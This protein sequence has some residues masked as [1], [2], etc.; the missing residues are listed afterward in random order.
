MLLELSFNRFPHLVDFGYFSAYIL[1]AR[2][3]V[4]WACLPSSRFKH[5]EWSHKHKFPPLT[6]RAP[7]Q[8]GLRVSLFCE[9]GFAHLLILSIWGQ[10]FFCRIE[11][12]LREGRGVTQ[13]QDLRSMRDRAWCLCE[14]LESE[15]H[16]WTKWWNSMSFQI[17][18]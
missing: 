14:F 7:E 16:V 6:V 11:A 9:L 12:S 13:E 15:T 3:Q 4:I 8:Q 2:K 10:Q 5:E 18:I 17:L 1:S